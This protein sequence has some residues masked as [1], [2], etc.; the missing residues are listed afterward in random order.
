M[1]AYDFEAENGLI[2][3]GYVAYGWVEDRQQALAICRELRKNGFYATC[4]THKF[5]DHMTIIYV[6]EKKDAKKK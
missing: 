1:G 4:Y 5:P 3:K 6:R 2:E